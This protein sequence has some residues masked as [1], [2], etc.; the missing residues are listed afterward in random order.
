LIDAPVLPPPARRSG[1]GAARV[2]FVG[3]GKSIKDV[4]APERRLVHVGQVDRLTN[5]R[6]VHNPHRLAAANVGIGVQGRARGNR[7]RRRDREVVGLTAQVGGQRIGK[8]GCRGQSDGGN[9]KEQLLHVMLP[10]RAPRG[11]LTAISARLSV[12]GSFPRSSAKGVWSFAE[13]EPGDA[14]AKPEFGLCDVSRLDRP[15]LLFWRVVGAKALSECQRARG[16][17][18]SPH[19]HAG[20]RRQTSRSGVTTRSR[21]R[22]SPA[23]SSQQ[24]SA[25]GAYRG[26][27]RHQVAALPRPPLP[28]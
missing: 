25:M 20:W 21:H 9:R 3:D 28:S 8:G 12:G 24:P 1:D 19:R 6:V 15:R 27:R 5:R 11:R 18:A 13:N 7:L 2:V 14:T 26:L 4:A 22:R 16:P 17:G 23:W 10:V